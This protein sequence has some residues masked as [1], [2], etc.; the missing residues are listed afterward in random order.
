[1]VANLGDWDMLELWKLSEVFNSFSLS[2]QQLVASACDFKKDFNS[3]ACKPLM[4]LT[5][6]V[7]YNQ[8]LRQPK[9]DDTT[10]IKLIDST[11]SL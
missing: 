8:S 9:L 1:M 4:G 6:A 2:L 3:Q 11:W 7:S 10:A 5:A